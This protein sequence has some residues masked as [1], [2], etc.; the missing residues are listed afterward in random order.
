[1][2]SLNSFSFGVK[3]IRVVLVDNEPQW[4][5]KD[6]ADALGYSRSTITNLTKTVD[7]VPAEWRGRYRIPT[8]SGDQDMVTLTEA[9]LF[10]FLNRSDK[11]A[12]LPM[13]KWVAGEVLPSIRKTG[14]YSVQAR[15]GVP[16][17]IEIASAVVAQ[18]GEHADWEQPLA[19]KIEQGR[20]CA[21][22]VYEME[23]NK[24]IPALERI[25]K[26]QTSP[27]GSA[28]A[29]EATALLNAISKVTSNPRAYEAAKRALPGL[30]P[31]NGQI[32]PPL[33]GLEG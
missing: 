11:P 25:E 10:F 22:A 12:A 17:A 7:H 1:M 23:K 13:Q 4:V 6:V 27:L 15:A 9:G 24:V 14:A 20:R 3:P 28:S 21:K 31:E 32:Q 8:P 2:H 19:E 18:L 5:A 16:T 29:K 26:R 30:F 33:P